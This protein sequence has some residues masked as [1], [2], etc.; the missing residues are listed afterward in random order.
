V[1]NCCGIYNGSAVFNR[2]AFEL[3]FGYSDLVFVD[4]TDECS[5]RKIDISEDF[6]EWWS[7]DPPIAAMT[8]GQLKG[9]SPGS[10]FGNVK[11]KAWEGY[12][13]NCAWVPVTMQVPVTVGPYQVEPIATASQFP[14]SCPAGQAGWNRN[15]TNQVQFVD[16]SA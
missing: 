11:G 13:T 5:N 6:S 3:Y 16:G 12:G 8:S 2:D 15:V 7:T 9:V 4:G 1:Q 14:A 10:T